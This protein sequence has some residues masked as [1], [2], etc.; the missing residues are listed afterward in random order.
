MN[1]V[2]ETNTAT[3]NTAQQQQNPNWLERNASWLTPVLTTAA[4]LGYNVWANDRNNQFNAEQAQ[5]NREWQEQQSSTAYQRGYADMKAAGLNPHLA[6]GNGG[7]STG[8]GGQAATTGM[9]PMDLNTLNGYALQ[10]AMTEAQVKNANADTELKQKQS[11]K[12]ASE[13]KAIEIDTAIK[14]AKAPLEMALMQ[15]QTAEQR[16]AA[17]KNIAHYNQLVKQLDEMDAHIALLKDQGK[18]VQAQAETERRL[19]KGIQTRAWIQ[20]ITG[21]I[22][23]TGIGVGAAMGGASQ[24]GGAMNAAMGG[25]AF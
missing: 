21:G 16:T 3:Q 8:G 24:M 15:A 23:D 19:Q 12:T 5:L 14:Q 1:D 18:Y 7:A 22:R 9:M 20:S 17:Q 11:G 4:Q 6:G 25:L 10:T 2:Y 13:Q